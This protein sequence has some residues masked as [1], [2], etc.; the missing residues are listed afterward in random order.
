MADEEAEQEYGDDAQHTRS[1]STPGVAEV[2]S[3]FDIWNSLQ[4]ADPADEIAFVKKDFSDMRMTCLMI[5]ATQL[6]VL[7]FSL[8]PLGVE[9]RPLT[10]PVLLCVVV[11]LVVRW[12]D[13]LH[14]RGADW[15][16][17]FYS[18]CTCSEWL[19]VI[20]AERIFGFATISCE[21]SIF[22][23][24]FFIFTLSQGILLFQPLAYKLHRA[25]MSWVFVSSLCALHLYLF[26]RFGGGRSRMDAPDGRAE[27]SSS[28]S[29]SSS[30]FDSYGGMLSRPSLTPFEFFALFE[31]SALFCLCL[32]VSQLYSRR[33]H[34]AELECLHERLRREKER[35]SYELAISHKQFQRD[36]KL[37]EQLHG[38]S[39][40]VGGGR[41]RSGPRSTRS[42]GSSGMSSGIVELTEQVTALRAEEAAK[43]EAQASAQSQEDKF[44]ESRYH[45]ERIN[46]RDCESPH[47]AAKRRQE[48][49]WTTL[50]DLGIRPKSDLS[51]DVHALL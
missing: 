41:A 16:G 3:V 5:N 46:E 26:A 23:V 42:V 18:L 19:I 43:D 36:A 48:A 30:T 21:N 22:L 17:I 38:G 24:L 44:R 7:P 39:R 10:W 49:L 51:D 33:L 27:N 8:T 13:D 14:E 2:N 32:V 50:A 40:S 1:L 6:L 4:F 11:Q 34:H 12:R 47:D 20:F 28:S 31:L 37:N 9:S 29:S 25:L 35:M 15:Y 45:V